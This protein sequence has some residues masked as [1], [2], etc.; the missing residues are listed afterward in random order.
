[1][2]GEEVLKSFKGRRIL[3]TG[4]TGLIG[5]QVVELLAEAGACLRVVSLDTV[6][7]EGA[8]HILGDLSEFRF[9]RELRIRITNSD[10]KPFCPYAHD[11]H[12]RP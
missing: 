3:I 9:C 4:G 1:M 12:Q 7:V 6:N 10:C 8:D 11:E 2:I 5:R